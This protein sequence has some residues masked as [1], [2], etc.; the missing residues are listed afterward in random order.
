MKKFLLVLIAA[1]FLSNLANAQ[2]N[3]ECNGNVGMGGLP[4]STQKVKITGTVRIT[5]GSGGSINIDNSGYSNNP[6]M[7]G[8]TTI[9][10]CYDVS[11][12]YFTTTS[13]ERL[14]ENIMDISNGLDL[15]L[16]LKGK[17]YDYKTDPKAD[18]KLN[19]LKKNHAGF[20]AQ[21][22]VKIIPEAVIYDDS[23]DIYSIDYTKIIPFITEAI[24]E[25]H[26][27]IE[28][29]QSEIQELKDNASN[30]NNLKSATLTPGATNIQNNGVNTLYQNAPNPFSQTT[31][32][33]YSLNEK[34]QKAMICIYD[35]NG[36][37]LKCIS[38]AL[39]LHGNITINGNEFKAGMYMYSLITDGQLIDTKRMILTD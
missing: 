6:R 30:T 39:S 31:T 18:K 10:G 37:Q 32:I 34:I 28:N 35:M 2:I 17:R 16:K 11:S 13:D 9:S 26:L 1:F 8:V 5:P 15:I 12:Y 27:V 25:Q 23:V 22:V 3:L 7:S 29:L 19:E 20:L 33:G 14:K 4:E 21:D 38:L 36:A 24:K